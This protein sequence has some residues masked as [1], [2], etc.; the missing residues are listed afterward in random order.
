MS[1]WLHFVEELCAS[2]PEPRP[3]KVEF[4]LHALRQLQETTDSVSKQRLANRATDLMTEVFQSDLLQ[5]TCRPEAIGT[6]CARFKN[7]FLTEAK[8]KHAADAARKLSLEVISLFPACEDL[9]E[10]QQRMYNER[11]DKKRRNA[12]ALSLTVAIVCG[13]IAFAVIHAWMSRK[14]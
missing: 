10:D 7:A 3:E 4:L 5:K 6:M 12:N 11:E 8:M 2:A 13:T 14:Y 9:L 1:V